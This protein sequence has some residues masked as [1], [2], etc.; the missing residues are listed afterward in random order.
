MSGV[1]FYDQQQSR[2]RSLAIIG[3]LIEPGDGPIKA[4]PGTLAAR[5]LLR[6]RRTIRRLTFAFGFH[7]H[8]RRAKQGPLPLADVSSIED[9]RAPVAQLDRALPSEARAFC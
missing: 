6:A 8:S 4:S 2:G 7:A 5:E 1:A 9:L 3:K